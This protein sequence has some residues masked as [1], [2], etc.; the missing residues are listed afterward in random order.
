[1]QDHPREALFVCDRANSDH[2]ADPTLLESTSVLE[3][4]NKLNVYIV[5][6]DYDNNSLISD[7]RN[8]DNIQNINDT[9]ID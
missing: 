2:R 9:K 7:L 4:S 6:F 3:L 5:P 8:R 1:M